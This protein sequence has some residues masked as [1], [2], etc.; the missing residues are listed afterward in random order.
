MAFKRSKGSRLAA[1][2]HSATIEKLYGRIP[3]EALEAKGWFQACSGPKHEGE[4]LGLRLQAFLYMA[5][6]RR[7]RVAGKRDAHQ[8]RHRATQIGSCSVIV[9]W[10]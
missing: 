1:F 4:V 5:V 8:C 6:A 2:A 3:A 7:R 9:T 10:V